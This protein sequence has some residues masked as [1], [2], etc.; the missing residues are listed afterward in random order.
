[1]INYLVFFIRCAKKNFRFLKYS[2][3]KK[4]RILYKNGLYFASG[5][6]Y[7]KLGQ[8]LP[9]AQCF[10][11][12]KAYLLAI[13][14]YEKQGLYSEAIQLAEMRKYYRIGAMLCEKIQSTKKAAFFYSFFNLPLAIKLYKK[15]GHFYEAGLCYM[16]QYKFGKAVDCFNRCTEEHLKILGLRQVEE[17]AITLY[18]IKEYFD[19]CELFIKLQDYFSALVCAK[20]LK[21]PQIIKDLSLLV[22]YEEYQKKNFAA[23]AKYIA[24]Y[25]KEKALLYHYMEQAKLS[26]SYML[27][28]MRFSA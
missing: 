13:K 18:F 11:K 25:D 12:S 1:M 7:Q 2:P 16:K 20:K 21:N 15:N 8:Y 24:P 26:A 19:A 9:A 28:Q 6:L 3:E 14:C 5:L 4:A 10:T 22:A 23:A 17:V 27:G